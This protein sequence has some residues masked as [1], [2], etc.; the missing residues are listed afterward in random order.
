MWPNGPVT[1]RLAG[2]LTVHFANGH[3]QQFAL[4]A[5][6][7]RPVLLVAPH[8]LG[9]DHHKLLTF[10]DTH[11]DDRMTFTLPLTNPSHVDA[12]WQIVH[13]RDTAPPFISSM[14]PRNLRTLSNPE[15]RTHRDHV[16]DPEAF[17][18]SELEGCVPGLSLPASAA[19]GIGYQHNAGA[20]AQPAWNRAREPFELRVFFKPKQQA[21]YHSRYRFQV[22][23][24][25]YVDIELHGV[26]TF[27]EQFAKRA[28]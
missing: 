18:F 22:T 8:E 7:Y 16:D 21:V 10:P 2:Q 28:Q 23:C 14:D 19:P 5:E 15:F 11:V 12:H 4:Q 25:E 13:V 3:R 24:G 6:L 20:G 1:Q 27:D 26:G 17:T 9:D